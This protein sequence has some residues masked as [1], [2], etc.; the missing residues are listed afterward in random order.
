[1]H[2]MKKTLGRKMMP[3]LIAW[4]GYALAFGPL[5]HVLG[6]TAA[7]VAMVPVAVT[8]WNLGMLGGLIAG[9]LSFPLNL[10][11]LGLVEGTMSG[12]MDL[13][14]LLGTALLVLVGTVVGRLYDLSERLREE[15]AR[16]ER[17]EEALQVSETRFHELFDRMS[18][19][20]AVYE[21]REDGKDFVFVDFN[22]AAERIDD[23]KRE[24]VIGK[25]VLE[26]FPDVRGFGLFDVFQRVWRTGKPEHFSS[27][28]YSDARITGWR[29]NYVY[30]L[31]SG[32]VVAAYDD[33]TGRRQAEK[34]LQRRANQLAFLNDVG[35]K[36]VA[37][38][39]LDSLLERAAQL[40]QES[41]GYYH[42]AL[43]TLDSEREELVMQA[44]AGD[45]VDLPLPNHRLKL[46]QGMVGWV[47]Q[48][49]E[50]LLANDVDA[51]PHYVNRYPDLIPTQSELSV[52]IQTGDKVVGV[53]DVQS[54][55][56]DAFNE[57]DVM[58]LETLAGQI[59]V[60]MDNARL[61]EAM[62]QELLE[63]KRA[64]DALQRRHQELIT[65]NAVSQALASSLELRETLDEAL[66]STI[67]M[68]GVTG[69]LIAI[70]DEQTGD[71]TLISHTGLPES[72]VERL[73]NSGMGGTLCDFVYQNGR[74]L[75]MEDLRKGAPVEASELLKMGLQSYAGMPIV[76]KGNTL[77][78]L[79][80]F[81]A[82]PYAIP[83]PTQAMLTTIGQQIGVAIENARLFEH[84][85]RDRE[86][87]ST[88]LDTAESLSTTLQFD[89]LLERVLDE[90]H[91]MVPYDSASLCLLHNERCQIAATRGARDIPSAKKWFTLEQY[92][93]IQRVVRERS[94]VVISNAHD[95]LDRSIESITGSAP[96]WL[97]MPL[98][99]RDRVIG[100]M[101]MSARQ[102]DAYDEGTA[103]LSYAFAHQV[104]LA[105]ENSRLYGQMRSQLREVTVLQGVT[106]AI[107]STLD[108]SRILPYVARSLCEI[109]NG[110]SVEIYSL[111]KETNTATV[112]ADYI[113]SR[114]IEVETRSALGHS[115]P[116]SN[117]PGTEEA[118][119]RRRPLQTQVDD[120]DADPRVRAY[121][122]ARGTQAMLLLPMVT[123]DHA[124]GFAQVWDS[125]TPHHF[126][127]GEIATGQ[128]LTHQAAIAME[129]ARL[130]K[131]TQERA[132]ELALLHDV[133]LAAASGLRLEETL[134]AAVET[135]AANLEETRVA[136]LLLDPESQAL[137]A[138][139]H[140]GYS[141]NQIEELEILPS[142]GITA[143]VAQHGEPALVPDVRQDDRYVEAASDV[144]SELC[145]PLATG[146]EVVGVLNVESPHLDAFTRDDLQVL[147]TLAGNLTMMIS[148]ARLFEEVEDARIELQR[149]AEALERAN[150]RLQELDRLKSQFLANMSHELRTPLNSI[151]GF[152]EVL[153][154]G[155][156]GE[157]TAEQ[158]ECVGNIY[159]SG[160]HLLAL[161]NDVLD[162]SKIEAGRM[163]L[164]LST[165]EIADLMDKVKTTIVPM[166]AEKSQALHIELADDLPPI[167][168]DQVR[169]KQIMLNLLSNAHKFTP[170]G[171]DITVSCR[172]VASHALL[173]SV[174]DTGI[175]IKPEDQEAVFEEFRQVDGSA[176]REVEGTGLGLA[177]SRQLVEMHGGR[178]W[179]D[180]EY[181]QGATF[182]FL[183]PIAGPTSAEPETVYE[184]GQVG[185]KTAL[186]VEDDRK[187]NNLLAF[188][189]RQEGY[190]PI[191]H[192]QG[193]GTLERTQELMPSLIT[194]DVMISQ[195]EGWQIL[196]A[197]KSNPRTREIPVLVVSALGN[198]DLALSLGAVDYLVKPLRQE[199]LRSV[200]NRLTSSKLSPRKSS[201]LIVDD[202]P[203]LVY[204][205]QEMLRRENYTSL[206]AF[207]GKDALALAR[208]EQPDVI[209]LDL[210][211]PKV[212]GFDVLQELRA[213]EKTKDIPVI[214]ITAKNVTGK[215]RKFLGD[216]IQ[217]LMYKSG[218]TPTV[219]LQ[220]VKRLESLWQRSKNAPSDLVG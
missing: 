85:I 218:L 86:V 28:L 125:S 185:G 134:Q 38:L 97:G 68:L 136:V 80:A 118:L 168:A 172:L 8:G 54:P 43:F 187:F 66:F 73:R 186:I 175:G 104:A 122:E 215:D 161:I 196:Q 60:A 133:G 15:L 137:R 18:S 130:F 36:I 142:E 23:I 22:R 174:T 152:S 114:A 64:E 111:D 52:P 92:P 153:Y 112:V 206:E 67:E 70:G 166:I 178:I 204:M 141:P 203:E 170:E 3:V 109:M 220:E 131:E 37:E 7:A 191:Q 200:L 165:F 57:N 93:S 182:S 144:R 94:P 9:L 132:R 49:G 208:Q 29:E 32:E 121:L 126:T 123:R 213:D 117:L 27:A 12:M 176:T 209:L 88:L 14:S 6:L 179:A 10:L 198:S 105:I 181:G 35:E 82:S 188:Y 128:T 106:A 84:A 101:T 98:I 159:V 150:E 107:S 173:F 47:A 146:S 217:G 113:P 184:E 69:G 103:R 156:V 201:V 91:R 115:E 11:L 77:G 5:N 39:E 4:I 46:G 55:Q 34:A 145:V 135:L 79:C 119:T 13:G 75:G 193:A 192:Y 194:L 99:S 51:E 78:A 140:T 190:E 116:L 45:F 163:E 83:E 30:Q 56:L 58:V 143:W 155:L 212:S 41:F 102:L 100:V 96:S 61:Y 171:G 50:T 33:V 42:A 189:L 183:L 108:M 110:T 48:H 26:V 139:A 138:Q 24:D 19:G 53:I 31:P 25:S 90:L 120:P 210:M 95:E 158:Q 20:V 214:V 71:L 164:T 147:S 148:N 195:H 197:L 44:Q 76:H 21:A 207:T 72:L 124:V 2:K 89:K 81:N 62:E 74:Y 169:I 199:E 167:N 16:R 180:S 40:V 59:A 177:I 1:M 211:M 205:V 162:L 63:H 154:D 151:I 160:E 202:D 17:A 216:R 129:N 127:S 149:R 157:L 65:L 87:A 219:L